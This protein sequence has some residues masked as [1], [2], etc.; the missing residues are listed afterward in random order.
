[1]PY[2]EADFGHL[3]EKPPNK[4]KGVVRYASL[5]VA[6]LFVD[7]NRVDK[8]NFRNLSNFSYSKSAT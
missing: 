1:M 7:L 8:L 3:P 6:S 2:L 5:R 4:Q